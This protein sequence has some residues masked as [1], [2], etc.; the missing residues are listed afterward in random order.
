VIFD[1]H[2]YEQIEILAKLSKIKLAEQIRR[3]CRAHLD[4]TVW[5]D[6]KAG[7]R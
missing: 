3:I 4:R 1:E 6:H 7:A 2:D 5:A